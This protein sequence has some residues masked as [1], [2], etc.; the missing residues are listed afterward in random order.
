MTGEVIASNFTAYF[1]SYLS[2]NSV[3]RFI[4]FIMKRIITTLFIFTACLSVSA[5][6][7]LDSDFSRSIPNEGKFAKSS[8]F[9][10][11]FGFSIEP[12]YEVSDRFQLGIQYQLN[13][14]FNFTLGE[15][16]FP[17]HENGRIESVSGMITF[18]PST[19]KMIHLSLGSGLY[20]VKGGY[21]IPEDRS[22]PLVA[23]EPYKSFGMQLN[24][25]WYSGHWKVGMGYTVLRDTHFITLGRLGFTI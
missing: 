24:V 5:Q 13:S 21:S 12:K 19:E 22:N 4:K 2:I 9:L 16:V 23:H 3:V 17:T 8:Y 7:H 18:R 15:D 14:V 10:G 1:F 25:N 11:G 6:F 20:F